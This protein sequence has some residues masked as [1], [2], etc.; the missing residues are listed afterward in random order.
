MRNNYF[1]VSIRIFGTGYLIDVYKSEACGFRQLS[2]SFALG[3]DQTA[4]ADMSG[5]GNASLDNL[6]LLVVDTGS[7]THKKHTVPNLIIC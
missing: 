4:R 2:S 3:T 1:D 6:V 7:F 5:S